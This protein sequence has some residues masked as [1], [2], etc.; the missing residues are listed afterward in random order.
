MSGFVSIRVYAELND[1]IPPPQRGTEHVYELHDKR[2][3][4]DLLESIGIPHTEI[5]LVL[6]NHLPVDFSFIVKGT[7]HIS[8][9]PVFRTLDIS[10]VTN[11]QPAPLKVPRFV[12][13]NHLGK[14]AAYLRM[15]GIDSLYRNNY[16]DSELADISASDNRILLTCDRQLLMRNQVTYGYF[17][18]SRKPKQQVIDVI[19]RYDLRE[20]LRP[21]TR[22][23][24]CNGS[25]FTVNKKD[26]KDLLA[27]DTREYYDRFWQCD[28][29]SRIYWQGSH[30]I[31]MKSVIE[32]ITRNSNFSRTGN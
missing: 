2:S 28:T 21:F 10:T 8:V 7:E 29:C 6:V 12:L 16:S 13:D 32:N 14:L 25:L 17:V 26:I 4:K 22:C 11:C 9:Y 31:K 24:K 27:P 1:L 18:R 15:M 5:G 3:I 23:I 20:Q 30:Y 19:T